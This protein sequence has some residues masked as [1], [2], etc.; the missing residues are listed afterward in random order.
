M[1]HYPLP[2]QEVYAPIGDLYAAREEAPLIVTAE[3]QSLAVTSGAR[4][5]GVERAGGGRIT[6]TWTDALGEDAYDIY[7]GVLQADTTTWTSPD[8][9]ES[10]Q[11]PYYYLIVP[12]TGAT[13]DYGMDN[14]GVPRP[15]SNTP[16][17]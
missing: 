9:Q 4:L 6:L 11:P 10:G 14:S 7:R 5:I 15:P 3:P 1:T 2:P 12:R 16:C 17:P 8:D 13:H